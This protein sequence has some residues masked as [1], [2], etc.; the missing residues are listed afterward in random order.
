MN[1]T[2]SFTKKIFDYKIIAFLF[3]ISLSTTFNT[4]AASD[5]ETVMVSSKNSTATAMSNRDI[6]RIFLGLRAINSTNLQTPVINESNTKNFRL[7][8]KNIM[9]LTERGYKRKLLKRVFRQGADNIESFSSIEELTSHL[10]N[11]PNNVSFMLKEDALK[12]SELKIIQ[13]LW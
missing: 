5:T 1:M 4:H 6:R 11:N 10:K 13:A 12:A 7:F 2:I 8:L 9:F 3:F